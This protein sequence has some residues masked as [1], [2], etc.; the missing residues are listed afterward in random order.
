MIM[1]Y[2]FKNIAEDDTISYGFVPEDKAEDKELLA[3]IAFKVLDVLPEA[4]PELDGLE[5]RLE[6]NEAEDLFFW[7][8]TE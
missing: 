8:P 3:T 5:Y 7:W 1:Y 6:Y 2:V 4:G